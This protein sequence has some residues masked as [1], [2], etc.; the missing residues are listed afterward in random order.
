MKEVKK[1]AIMNL[2][3][4][5]VRIASSG[6]RHSGPCENCFKT[7]KQTGIRRIVFSGNDG[8]F[9]MH[10]VCNYKSFHITHG[11]KHIRS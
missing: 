6:I 5:V 7:I 11:F 9:E 2:T 1:G 10:D 8:V 4:Y 3:L